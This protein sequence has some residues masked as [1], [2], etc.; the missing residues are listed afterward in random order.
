MTDGNLEHVFRRVAFKYTPT[1][2]ETEKQIKDLSS[3]FVFQYVIKTSILDEKGQAVATIG[4]LDE[5]LDG[6]IVQQMSQNLSFAVPFLREV[7]NATISKFNLTS[8]IIVD[9]LFKSPIFRPDK[10]ALF[11][12][13][14][15]SFLEKDYIAFIH[16]IIPQI[17]FALRT[18]IEMGGGAIYRPNQYGGLYLKPLDHVLRE[19]ITLNVLGEDTCF[20]LRVLLTDPRGWNVRN[21]VCHGTCSSDSFNYQI[22]DRLFHILLLLAQL[23]IEEQNEM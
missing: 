13:G 21:S 12:A 15:K 9:E 10:K 20:Y 8:D 22:A 23:R 4:P 1:K 2:N 17:E 18:I 19:E 5:D 11:V 14:L 6:H 16:L 3:K 7:I